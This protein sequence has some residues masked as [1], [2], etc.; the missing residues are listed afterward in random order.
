MP[1]DPL[2]GMG[3]LPALPDDPGQF[4]F[5]QTEDGRT[6]VE[7]RFC[8]ETVWLSLN[9]MAE[10]FQRDKSVV[11]RHV[12]NV[13]EEC[14]LIR[15]ATVAEFAAVQ[16]EGLRR[17]ERRIAYYSLDVIISVGY[18]VKSHRGSEDF[19]GMCFGMGLSKVLCL[20]LP[21]PSGSTAVHEP[22]VRTSPCV[23]LDQQQRSRSSIAPDCC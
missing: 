11:S 10:L 17:V 4:I 12:A 14:E 8:R 21:L 9:Q 5:Y 1:D 6:R 16:P 3:S 22:R 20:E 2:N 23:G 13:F 19:R 15:E 7:V 18:R